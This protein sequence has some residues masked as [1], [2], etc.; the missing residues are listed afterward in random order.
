MRNE[1]TP[2]LSSY[3]GGDGDGDGDEYPPPDPHAQFC[4]MVGVPSSV[5]DANRP[6][7]VP[8]K[9]LYGR[10]TRE[11]GKQRWTYYTTAG[12]SNT[13]LLSQVILGAALTALGASE[14]SHILITIF[15]AMNTVIAGLVAYLK[16]RGQPMR[17]RMYRDDLERVVDEIENSEVMWMGIARRVNGYDEIDTDEHQVTVRSEVARLSRLYDRAVRNNTVNNPDMY[18]TGG[19][20]EGSTATLRARPT[21]TPLPVVAV[22]PPVVA[23]P[24]VGAAPSAPPVAQP[25]PAQTVPDPDESPATAPPKPKEEP[26][27][28]EPPKEEPP[29]EA[30]KKNDDKKDVDAEAATDEEKAP[31]K[32]KEPEPDQGA[33]KGDSS[34]ASDSPANDV[35]KTSGDASAPP[36]PA[37]PAP[38]PDAEPATA[39]DLPKKESPKPPNG[40]A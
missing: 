20:Y 29:K 34:S 19:G 39:P 26:P 18:M 25:P 37:T 28:E 21:P 13:L 9:S 4:M 15:G 38:D 5:P 32:Q 11:L 1:R 24:V 35:T 10:V 27:K 12:L 14:S 7:S 3:D 30:E 16:S 36:P 17:A 40:E 33:K 22:P 8:R 31:G 6:R 23:T 2:L